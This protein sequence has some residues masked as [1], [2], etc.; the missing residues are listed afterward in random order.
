MHIGDA[1]KKELEKQ[2]KTVVWLADELSYSRTNIYKIFSKP[3]IDTMVLRRI[4]LVL[5]IDFFKIYSDEMKECK[6]QN[7]TF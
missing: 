5:Q 7:S 1:I 4:S 3:S 2:G 6:G